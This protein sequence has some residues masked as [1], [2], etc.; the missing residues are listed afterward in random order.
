MGGGG[1]FLL[2]CAVANYSPTSLLQSYFNGSTP[3]PL[4]SVDTSSGTVHDNG[5][6]NGDGSG[7][8]T[9]PLSPGF[10][11]P[12]QSHLGIGT[13]YVTTSGEIAEYPA[14]YQASPATFIQA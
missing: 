8:D 14:A 4:S 13:T 3:T 6:V 5:S 11:A 10:N 2:Y 9:D 7:S 12:N 1:V